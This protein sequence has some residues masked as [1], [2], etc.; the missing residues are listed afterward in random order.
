MVWTE[1]SSACSLEHSLGVL[2]RLL[3]F[4][5]FHVL[6]ELSLVIDGPE[7]IGLDAAVLLKHV[8]IGEVVEE[9]DVA[10]GQCDPQVFADEAGDVLVLH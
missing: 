6:L 3:A 9:V 5:A 10:V 8:E 7:L 2:P 4:L 1:T